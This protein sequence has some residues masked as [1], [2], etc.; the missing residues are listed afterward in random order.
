VFRRERAVEDA[1]VV[2]RVAG[3]VTGGERF[4]AR[5]QATAVPDRARPLTPRKLRLA[6]SNPVE[7]N[8]IERVSM[9]KDMVFSCIQWG[10]PD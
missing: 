6:A 8:A 1:D 2:G 4:A 5:Q 9:R 10:T 7:R 3:L